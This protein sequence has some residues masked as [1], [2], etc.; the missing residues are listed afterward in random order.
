[1]SV[2]IHQGSEGDWVD[3]PMQITGA[4]GTVLCPQNI[5]VEC[6]FWRGALPSTQNYFVKIAPTNVALNFTLRV[7]INPP[8][9]VTQTFQYTNVKQNITFSYMDDFAPTRFPGPQVYKVEPEIALEMIDSQFYVKTNLIEAYLL[10]GSTNDS[11]IVATCTQPISFGGSENVVGDVVINGNK[12]V[13]SEGAGVGAGN[14]Y[15]QVYHRIA[16]NGYC[17]EVTFFFHYANIG[18]YPPDSGVKEF[19]RTPLLQK[20]ESVLS[21]LVIN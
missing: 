11:R 14:V 3:I 13:R 18:N 9:V 16:L 7:A 21:T 20:F 1:M 2:S 8:G 4:D 17:Y 10:F 19:D 12:F 15:E 5:N 6:A